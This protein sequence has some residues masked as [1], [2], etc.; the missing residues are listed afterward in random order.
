MKNLHYYIGIPIA[1][2]VLRGLH[3]TLLLPKKVGRENQICPRLLAPLQLLLFSILG[4]PFLQ[5]SSLPPFH[6]CHLHTHKKSL[7]ASV[8]N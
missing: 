5:T 3:K 7:P 4:F 6:V 1:F 2:T 8:G